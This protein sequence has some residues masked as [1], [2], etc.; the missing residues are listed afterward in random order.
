M[1]V[2]LHNRDREPRVETGQQ[3]G[4]K[5]VR[6]LSKDKA[7]VIKATRKTRIYK[8]KED[9]GELKWLQIDLKTSRVWHRRYIFLS[10]FAHQLICCA[11]KRTSQFLRQSA[12]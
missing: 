7:V 12:S 4:S 10:S 3:P 8:T 11:L 6:W 9:L 2:S 1:L 5:R